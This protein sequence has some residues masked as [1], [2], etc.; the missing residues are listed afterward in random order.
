MKHYENDDDH[1]LRVDLSSHQ[2]TPEIPAFFCFCPQADVYLKKNPKTVHLNEN[3]DF[4]SK[5]FDYR[6]KKV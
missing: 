4:L 5:I 6:S 3:S 1:H 2:K